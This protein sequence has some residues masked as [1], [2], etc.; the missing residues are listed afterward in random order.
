MWAWCTLV[1][2]W[3]S[4]W[5]PARGQSIDAQRTKHAGYIQCPFLH[6]PDAHTH[7]PLPRAGTATLTID[8]LAEARA[9]VHM[10][11]RMHSADIHSILLHDFVLTGHIRRHV[12]SVYM[13]RAPA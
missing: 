2:R 8:Q 4:I 6:E 5:R 3:S 13:I 11:L 10:P 9:P 12:C 7:T 1:A